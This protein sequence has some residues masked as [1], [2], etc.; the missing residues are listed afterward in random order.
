MNAPRQGHMSPF[1]SISRRCEGVAMNPPYFKVT[2]VCARP[3]CSMTSWTVDR[4]KPG[5]SESSSPGFNA[6]V[7][8]VCKYWGKVTTVE[9]VS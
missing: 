6:L 1:R 7:C 3:A 4:K 9:E 5:N 8:P 2:A